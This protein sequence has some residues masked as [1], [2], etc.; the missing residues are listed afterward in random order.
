MAKGLRL[1]PVILLLLGCGGSGVPGPEM[2]E[3]LQAALDSARAAVAAT[4]TDPAAARRGDGPVPSPAQPVSAGAASRQAPADA[5]MD[6]PWEMSLAA[7]PGVPAAGRS[8]LPA[9]PGHGPPAVAGH[10]QA[11]GMLPRSH[12]AP[13]GLPAHAAQLLG[14]PSTALRHW[15]GEPSLRRRDGPAEIWLYLGAVCAL[16]VIL[17]EEP[18]RDAPQVGFAAARATGTERR[19]EAACLRELATTARR[20]GAGG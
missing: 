19:S 17:Y 11:V 20:G 10:G 8:V 12:E 1:V 13:P 15:L 9:V 2:A 18:G 4:P 5:P 3:A 14:L 16:D 7:T 6:A